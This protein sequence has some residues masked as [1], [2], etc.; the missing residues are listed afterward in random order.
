[1]ARDPSAARHI[2]DRWIDMTAHVHDMWTPRMEVAT[3]RG[4]GR[5]RHVTVE[6]DPG[7]L[8]LLARV[9]HGGR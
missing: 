4:I 3:G 6:H 9:G 5:T 1:M 7:A 2:D 8:T